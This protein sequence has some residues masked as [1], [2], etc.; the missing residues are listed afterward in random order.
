MKKLIRFNWRSYGLLL[1]SILQ[2]QQL[3]AVELIDYL[4][5]SPTYNQQIPTPAKI[6]NF[7]VGEWHVRPEQIYQYMQQLA[8][9]S[10]RVKL[11]VI[12]YTH[13]KRPLILVYISAPEN[14]ARLAQIRQQHLQQQTDNT[15]LITWM[16]YSVHGN[17]A[18]GSNA[19]LLLAYHLASANDK[20]TLAQ[21]REQVIIIDPMLNP[22][23]LAR[24]AHWVNSTQSYTKNLDSRDIEH[25]EAWPSG[26]TNHYWF[27]LNRDWLLLQH[28]ESQARVAQF[29]RW[30]PQ[31]LTD[32]HEMGTDSTYFF[33]PGEHARHNPLIADSNYVMT[34]KIANYHAKALDKIG[35][36]YYSRERFDDFYFG[37]GSTYPDAHGSVGILFEQA[38]ARGH[39]QQSEYGPLSFAKA[40]RHH[41]AT[42]FS[43]IEAAQEN[44]QALK[45]MRKHFITETKAL[46]KDDK[47]R[48]VVIASQ[49]KYRMHELLN[50]LQQHQ[51]QYYPLAKKVSVNKQAYLPDNSYIIP[52]Q[53]PQYRLITSLFESRKSFKDT[54]FYDV[55]SWNF[56]LAFDVDYAFVSRSDFSQSLLANASSTN[57]QDLEGPIEISDEV[58][59]LGFDW[60]D[61][62]SVQMIQLLQQ[63]GLRLLS[64]MQEVSYHQPKLAS[65]QNTRGQDKSRQNKGQAAS[66]AP[67][68]VI[69]TLNDQ[70][71]SREE[72]INWV[73]DELAKRT[74]QPKLITSGLALHGVDLGSPDMPVL[75]PVKPL[76]IIGDGVSGYDAGEAWHFID[77][78]LGLPL[79]RVTSAQ[80]KGVTLS[81]YTHLLL[82]HGRYQFNDTTKQKIIDWI[83]QGGHLIA[84]S[85]GARWATEQGLTSSQVK[86]FEAQ[87]ETE[88]KRGIPYAERQHYEAKHYV[89]GAIAQVEI[90]T[91]HPIGF[92]LDNSQIAIFKRRTQAFELPNEAF[93][94]IAR[95]TDKPHVAG[96][97]SAK[98]SEHIKGQT[99]IMVQKLGAGNVILFS[100]N[101]LFRGIWLGS[102]RLFAN[103]L[104]FAQHI[105]APA[106]SEPKTKQAPNKVDESM[107]D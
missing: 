49:D 19:S 87:E 77:Q 28:P 18:S 70:S 104:F 52:L 84:H 85:G 33:Q 44:R 53:Q 40:I 47:N 13:E 61:F 23:G 11:E 93:S 83:Q 78:R 63:K 65:Q 7:E 32:F 62:S 73:V 99:A 106:K 107:A 66:L 75:K 50:I 41:L 24:F 88:V 80:L 97:M 27:D 76:L 79:T 35:A 96:Y 81:N 21:L 5:D 86:P 89:G 56:G 6:L 17:E 46:A 48:A 101:P 92:G 60:R 102:S 29:H 25:H 59:A 36:L 22:D 54:I 100:D 103:A 4:P 94:A 105:D 38:S 51:I 10:D 58:I 72:V 98:V 26:R 74:Y 12:G 15:P 91:T 67:G 82:V 68:S 16:G 8:A 57:R 34:Q 69:L 42:S 3:Q 55:S 90:D 43:T 2:I 20:Q 95:F 30:R 14:I 45:Q 31:I 9:N 71:I 37:K 64:S 39:Y 1:L